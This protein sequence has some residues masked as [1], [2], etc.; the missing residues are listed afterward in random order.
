MNDPAS[1]DRP[2]LAAAPERPG[3][4]EE[5]ER[6]RFIAAMRRVASSVSVI[7]T[8]T[9][10]GRMA[11]TVSSFLSI[12]ADPPLVAV[13]IHRKSPMAA[14]V[15][16]SGILAVHV[17]AEHQGDVADTFAGRPRQGAPYDLS[18][19]EWLESAEGGEPVLA[20]AAISLEGRIVGGHDA[21]SHRLF[22][23]QVRQVRLGEHPPLLYWDRAYS[24]P[25]KIA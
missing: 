8:M 15:D 25:A 22:I 2:V 4:A 7:T 17:L 13:C 18:C 14:A 16:R 10:R 9:D 19:T 21:G 6:E 3:P 20:G 5:S 24:A 11:L 1:P 23:A 12:S